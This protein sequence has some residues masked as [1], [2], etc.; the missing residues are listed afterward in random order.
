MGHVISSTLKMKQMTWWSQMG[1]DLHCWQEVTEDLNPCRPNSW[2]KIAITMPQYSSLAHV[3]FPLCCSFLGHDVLT[4]F[5][6]QRDRNT[7]DTLLHRSLS[8]L[9]AGKGTTAYSSPKRYF[10]LEEM[11]Y[12][13]RATEK[14]FLLRLSGWQILMISTFPGIM[15]LNFCVYFSLNEPALSKGQTTV[16]GA[17]A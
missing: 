3:H 5:P 2:S 11:L 1:Q 13:S 14:V 6:L 4:W 9:L 7:V 17:I 16:P 15:K 12:S 8:S 10:L